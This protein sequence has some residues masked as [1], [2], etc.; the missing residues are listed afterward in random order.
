M[1]TAMTKDLAE[2]VTNY[3]ELWDRCGGSTAVA[4]EEF[5]DARQAMR[6]ALAQPQTS[7]DELARRL[8]YMEEKYGKIDWDAAPDT[9]PNLNSG[10]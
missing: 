6:D 7:Q 8:A 10:S 3:F 4:A 5:A 9:R 1:E 2:A